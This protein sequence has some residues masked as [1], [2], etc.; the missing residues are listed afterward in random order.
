MK[1]DEETEEIPIFLFGLFDSFDDLSLETEGVFRISA[2]ARELARVKY[3]IDSGY[4]VDFKMYGIHIRSNMLKTFIR[5]LPEP[6]F[7]KNEYE[8]VKNIAKLKE[9]KRTS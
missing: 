5:E 1:R 9:K 8:K 4:D 3:L 6:L 7:P 2:D